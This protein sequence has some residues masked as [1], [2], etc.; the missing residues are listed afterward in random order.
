MI[1][2]LIQDENKRLHISHLAQYISA[3][4]FNKAIHIRLSEDI[5]KAL[6][7]AVKVREPQ[8]VDLDGECCLHVHPSGR[9]T[10]MLA[11]KTYRIERQ[12]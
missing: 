2:H 6:F 4:K 11:W 5:E 8:I 9:I 10:L 3:W 1:T 7:L 12:K